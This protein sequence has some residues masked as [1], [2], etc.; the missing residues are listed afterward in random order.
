MHR[1]GM[2]FGSHTMSHPNLAAID[3][4]T[5]RREMRDSKLRLE[6]RL[7]VPIASLAYPF[8]KLRHHVT[9]K[10]VDLARESGYEQAV[11]TH[12]RA[13][14][15]SDD[16]LCLPRIVIGNET[17]SQLAEKVIGTIDWHAHVRARLPRALSER[18]FSGRR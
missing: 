2:A 4:A 15:D 13:I 18:S 17:V 3:C 5:A 9:G 12:A 1:S 10:T 8:G 14:A 7:Q 6:D 11:S 16:D